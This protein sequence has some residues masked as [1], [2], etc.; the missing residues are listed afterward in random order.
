MSRRL[1]ENLIAGLIL[2][3]F[4][5]AIVASLQYG[6]RARMVPI[7]IATLGVI[8]IIAQ[9]V[10]QNVRSEKDLKID[11]LEVIARKS[12]GFDESA[13]DG[14]AGGAEQKD[15]GKR[16]AWGEAR[17]LGIVLLLVALFIVVGPLPAMFIFTAGYFVVSRHYA[18]VQSL[19]YA[20]AYTLLVYAVFSLW[21]RVDLMRGIVD[22][23]FGLI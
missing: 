17:A 16:P 3:I 23:S 10:L 19:A 4:V 1:Q 20:A 9:I 22:V 7:P 8:L 18:V 13:E 21:L 6:P 11:L 12:D 2:A 14:A 5:A 15:T